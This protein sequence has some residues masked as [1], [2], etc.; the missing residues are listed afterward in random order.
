[1]VKREERI[2]AQESVAVKAP[3]ECDLRRR[4]TRKSM[5]GL[6]AKEKVS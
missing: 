3:E 5:R 6:F 1:V 2:R 4:T